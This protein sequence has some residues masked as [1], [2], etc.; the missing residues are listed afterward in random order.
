MA[1]NTHASVG[2]VFVLLLF[3]CSTLL[4]VVLKVLGLQKS[5]RESQPRNN[6]QEP[7]DINTAPTAVVV[8]NA[9]Q[10]DPFPSK[11]SFR[12]PMSS[13]PATIKALAH[14]SAMG[15]ILL[16]I[17]EVDGPDPIFVHGGKSYSR[18]VFVTIIAA[19]G[20]VS[21]AMM[22]S[23]E[24]PTTKSL[25]RDQTEEWRGWMQ[26]VFVLYHYFDA[27]EVYSMLTHHKCSNPI[28]TDGLTICFQNSIDQGAGCCIRLDDRF[29][30]L[31]LFL[32]QERFLIAADHQNALQ[33]IP[34]PF[35]KTD[36]LTPFLKVE[37]FG[38]VVVFDP[39]QPLDTL[40]HMPDAHTVVFGNVWV[41]MAVS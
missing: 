14:F 39:K 4:L 2:Q 3:M 10:D 21:I 23:T 17:Y 8:T 27:K 5:N 13:N 15:L 33:V 35:R 24:P 9:S 25:N 31:H 16:F 40:L 29:W 32:Y 30:E 20:M 11:N 34:N 37:F 12:F 26:A 22:K 41:H 1:D 36:Q 18:T 28:N 19:L 6:P 7:T 38:C